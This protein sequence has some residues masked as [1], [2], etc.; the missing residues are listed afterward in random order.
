MLKEVL[1]I[2]GRPGLFKLISYAK[3]LIVVESLLDGKRYGAHSR[4]RVIA[5]SDI[6]IFTT[7]EDLPLGK[8]LQAVFDKKNGK[9]V[10]LKALATGEQLRKFMSDVIPE[11]D[12]ERV[13]TSD[14][15][16]LISWYNILVKSG[17]T[18]FLPKEE[19]QAEGEE[20]KEEKTDD[21]A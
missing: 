5:L 13:H 17:M 3:N 6:A 16:K 14:I 10:D 7:G 4:D 12:Q 15:K 9:E 2:S 21:K 19:E 20:A 18:N 1:A 8:A 11:F